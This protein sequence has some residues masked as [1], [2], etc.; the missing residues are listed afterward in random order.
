MYAY[1]RRSSSVVKADVDKFYNYYPTIDDT[2][3]DEMSNNS[4]TKR[5]YNGLY[6]HVKAKKNVRGTSVVGNPGAAVTTASQ[7]DVADVVIVFE[8]DTPLM[9]SGLVPPPSA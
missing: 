5:Y 4:A 1:G 3:F 9:R 8:S 6:Q 7:L 2:F